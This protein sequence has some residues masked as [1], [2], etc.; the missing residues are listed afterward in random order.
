M[1]AKSLAHHTYSINAPPPSSG[2][3]EQVR[4]RQRNRHRGRM[5]GRK[6]SLRREGCGWKWPGIQQVLIKH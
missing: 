3:K 1:L 4:K 6:D 2:E 5:E